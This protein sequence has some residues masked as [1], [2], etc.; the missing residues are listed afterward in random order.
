M[1]L[2]EAVDHLANTRFFRRDVASMTPWQVIR[3]WELRRIAYNLIVGL[4]TVATISIM[5]FVAVICDKVMGEP[6]GMPDPRFAIRGA[7]IYAVM[8]NV[9]FTG[10]WLVELLIVRA[11]GFRHQQFAR[12]AFGLG[13]LV[14]V[15]LT[16]LPAALTVVSAAVALVAYASGVRGAG[17][18]PGS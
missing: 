14:S 5:L 11:W 16:L 18:A 1:T 8:A 9:C 3:W 13:L 17:T 15:A 7:I 12:V 4:A 6:I 10:S 2:I